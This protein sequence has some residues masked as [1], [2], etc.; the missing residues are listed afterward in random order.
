MIEILYSE[1]RREREREGGGGGGGRDDLVCKHCFSSY[2]SLVA[3]A[4]LF[5]RGHCRVVCHAQSFSSE[6]N[7]F[8]PTLFFSHVVVWLVFMLIKYMSQNEH[9][10][11]SVNFYFEIKILKIY[12]VY[13]CCMKCRKSWIVHI[14]WQ[15]VTTHSV[16]CTEMST[17]MLWLCWR[18]YRFYDILYSIQLG[19][20]Y[21]CIQMI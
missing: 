3:L 10:A 11:L 12:L 17:M 6:W 20:I 5:W 18:T 7:M 14:V 21:A 19:T 13:S 8:K 2:C 1:T 4:T 15:N 16:F 9:S